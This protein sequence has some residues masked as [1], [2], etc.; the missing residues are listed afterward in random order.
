[1]HPSPAPWA[2]SLLPWGWRTGGLQRPGAPGAHLLKEEFVVLVKYGRLCGTSPRVRWWRVAR[3]GKAARGVER[4]ARFTPAAF[5]L[6]TLL[7]SHRILSR[8]KKTQR[9]VAFFSRARHGP[10]LFGDIHIIC[11]YSGDKNYAGNVSQHSLSR[12]RLQDGRAR[13]GGA[14][15]CRGGTD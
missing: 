2:G 10:R 5:E 12:G 11:I 8:H 14:S 4:R 3:R 13:T 6:C 7:Y 9:F 1:M 15:S